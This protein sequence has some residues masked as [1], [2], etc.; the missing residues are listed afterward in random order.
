[1]KQASIRE[2]K[3]E[4]RRVLDMVESGQTLEICRRHKPVA[5]LSPPVKNKAVEM[6]DFMARLQKIYGDNLLE[7]TGTELIREARGER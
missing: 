5:I 7:T 6:P 2:I 1:M 3:H 4:T